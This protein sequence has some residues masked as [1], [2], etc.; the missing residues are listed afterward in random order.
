MEKNVPFINLRKSKWKKLIIKTFIYLFLFMIVSGGFGSG[1]LAGLFYSYSKDLPSIAVLESFKPS[2]VTKLYSSDGVLLKTVYRENRQIIAYEQLPQNLINAFI[3][4]EDRRF[5]QHGGIDYIGLMRALFRDVLYGKREGASTITMQLARNI[6]NLGLSARQVLS[7]KIKE[8][9]LAYEIEQTYSKNE[10]LTLYLNQIHLGG[11]I[12]GAAAAAEFYFGKNIGQLSLEECAVLAGMPKAPTR[13][14]PLRNPEK[15]LRRRNIVLNSM[16]RHGFI[17]KDRYENAVETPL[18]VTSDE[19]KTVS[20]AP[21]FTDFVLRELVQKYGVD[22]VYEGGLTVTTTL[23][24]KLQEAAEKALTE[25]MKAI[26]NGMNYEYKLEPKDST[27]VQ[28][29]SVLVTST[30]TNYVQSSALSIRSDDAAVLLMIGGRNYSHSTFNRATQIV[31]QPGS[32]MKPFVFTAGFLHG[33]SPSDILVDAPIII[34]LPNGEVYKPKNYEPEY[35]GPVNIYYALA[36]SINTIAVQVAHK[37]GVKTIVELCERMGFE[38]EMPEVLSLALGSPDVSLY[39]ITKAYNVFAN[40][41]KLVEPYSVKE[42]KDSNGNTIYRHKS[43]KYQVLD[44]QTN[45]LTVKALENVIENGTGRN[46]RNRF[47]VEGPLAGKTGTTNDQRDGWFLGFSSKITT[48]VWGGFDKRKFLGKGMT[49]AAVALPIWSKIM[50]AAESDSIHIAGDS[51][52]YKPDGVVEI[53]VCRESGLLPTKYCPDVFKTY[54][55]IDN[56]PLKRCNIHQKSEADL[57]DGS[58]D[59]TDDDDHKTGSEF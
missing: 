14:N 55:K 30:G 57:I 44:P 25:H 12:H 50:K 15:S 58:F 37:I 43:V 52:F 22:Y 29:D 41:G 59:E 27:K 56:I 16:Y 23:N 6:P 47:H 5:Y 3:A 46:A 45:Y 24:Y 2:L 34:D 9:L 7:R 20:K 54:F 40:N 21:Y 51:D 35:A 38:S 19:K 49:G 53:E 11:R 1:I 18:I 33:Y 48:G 36:H 10:I 17:S 31:R 28:P 26:E 13:Y 39:E 32:A 8:M 42:I 4:I